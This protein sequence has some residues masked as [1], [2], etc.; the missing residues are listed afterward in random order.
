MRA[1]A[2]C[3]DH[4]A[5][6]H[7][8]TVRPLQSLSQ[9]PG[10]GHLVRGD[11]AIRDRRDLDGQRWHKVAFRVVIG[12]RFERDRSG[13]LVLETGGQVR[14]GQ[15]RGLP[16]E[17]S[18]DLL[19]RGGARR[20]FS[21]SND[22]AQAQNPE[23]ERQRASH[24]GIRAVTS[25]SLGE[26]TVGPSARST[27]P[28]GATASA[29]VAF[30]PGLVLSPIDPE[31]GCDLALCEAP[32]ARLAVSILDPKGPVRMA[33]ARESPRPACSR[34]ACVPLA[35]SDTGGGEGSRGEGGISVAASVENLLVSVHTDLVERRV[36]LHALATVEGRDGGQSTGTA[37]SCLPGA[38][39]PS[40]AGRLAGR[41]TRRR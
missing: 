22:Q 2:P 8:A 6:R 32:C 25:A 9:L 28:A 33:R 30:E 7:V 40:G 13:I 21:A 26:A 29:A 10:N 31:G 20:G 23:S 5:G 27:L 35:D 41:G 16:I 36:P 17:E 18:Q 39:P 12:Q 24:G 37:S 19:I 11:S 4:V 3:E 34:A 38:R 1:V 15:R 14:A